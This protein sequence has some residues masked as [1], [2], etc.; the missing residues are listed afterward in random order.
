[1]GGLTS[2]LWCEEEKALVHAGPAQIHFATWV[3]IDLFLFLAPAVL[4]HLTANS[5]DGSRNRCKGIDGWMD[6]RKKAV[7][8]SGFFLIFVYLSSF[9][10]TVNLNFLS[11]PATTHW[12][13]YWIFPDG[14]SVPDVLFYMNKSIICCFTFFAE[15]IWRLMKKQLTRCFH[16]IRTTL[17]L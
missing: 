17:P 2:E 3:L 12:G 9:A 4:M 6:Q 16:P 14:F 1:M 7:P 13:F 5:N 10:S 8:V 11:L 15:T